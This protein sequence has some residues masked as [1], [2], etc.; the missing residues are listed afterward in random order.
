MAMPEA[1]KYFF[2]NSKCCQCSAS[3]H[4]SVSKYKPS[5]AFKSSGGG[6]DFIFAR[7]VT[8]ISAHDACHG[9]LSFRGG[10]FTRVCLIITCTKQFSSFQMRLC[11]C[12]IRARCCSAAAQHSFTLIT[13]LKLNPIFVLLPSPPPP[14]NACCVA[15][16]PPPLLMLM[17]MMQ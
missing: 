8:Y 14:S 3:F 15:L 5:F 11:H 6:F 13:R 7:R 16:N 1:S 12:R 9:K 4:I 10:L 2:T 17:M